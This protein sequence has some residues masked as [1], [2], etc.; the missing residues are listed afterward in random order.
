ME[1]GKTSFTGSY[2]ARTRSLDYE[3]ARAL[4]CATKTKLGPVNS[5]LSCWLN[6][7]IQVLASRKRPTSQLLCVPR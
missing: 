2:R 7:F 4:T 3:V 5:D 1:R 6:R